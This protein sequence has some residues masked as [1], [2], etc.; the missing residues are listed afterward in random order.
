[1]RVRSQWRDHVG[2]LY[3]ANVL[4]VCTFV[5]QQTIIK[6]PS[7]PAGLCRC[8]L[9]SLPLCAP[10][11]SLVALVGAVKPAYLGFG[12]TRSPLPRPAID[13]LTS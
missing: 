5:H 11:V 3:S 13:E 1:M 6:R 9:F 7:V 8:V 12:R 4:P 10:S 2:S